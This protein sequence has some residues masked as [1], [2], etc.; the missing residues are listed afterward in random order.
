MP[1]NAKRQIE[2]LLTAVSRSPRSLLMLDY[3]GTLAPF[4]KER[5]QAT[6]YPGISSVI[7]KIIRSG[8]SR[9]VIISGRDAGDLVRLINIDPHPEIW[10]FHG[11]QRLMSD[12]CLELS[13]LDPRTISA[14]ANAENW[15]REQNLVSAAEFKTGSI[16]VHWR[17]LSENEAESIRGRALMGWISIARHSPLKLFEFDG[18][19]EIRGT[20]ADK[21]DAVRTILSEMK[22]KTPAAYL[23]DDTTDEHAFAAIEGRGLSVLVRPRK[24]TT[25]AQ[26]WLKP[27]D[28]LLDFLMWWLQ[29]VEQPSSWSPDS[30]L[31]INL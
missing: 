20:E 10:G 18:G 17:G 27:P 5:D 6:P 15:L 30:S 14:L 2:E 25:A 28:E 4:R 21:G 12:G 29:A 9:V 8:K 13:P 19:V 26:V 3:D 11:L 24:R 1:P 23:G 16:A 31:R 7:E 22:F